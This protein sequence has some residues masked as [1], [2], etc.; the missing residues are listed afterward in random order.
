MFAKRCFTTMI[1][2]LAFAGLQ[3]G[4]QA[5]ET[6]PNVLLIAI[7]DL[8]DWVGCLG[9]HPDTRTPN[10]DRLAERGVLF[11]NSHSQAPICNPSRSSIMLG[12]RP[13]TTGIYLNNPKHWLVPALE[14]RVTMPRHFAAAGYTTLTTGKI[15]HGS[16][17]PP[18]DFDIVGPRPGQRIDLDEQLQSGFPSS[19]AKLWDFGPQRY[20]EA[21]FADHADATWA[22]GQLEQQRDRPFFIAVG[23]YRPH[24]PFYSPERVFRQVPRSEISLPEVREDDWADIPEIARKL[25]QS[26]A[27]P[28]SWFVNSGKWTDAVQSYLSCVRWTDEQ[29][30]RLL[31][32]LEANGHAGNTVVVLY[33]DH[34]FHL[35]EKQRWAKFSLWERSTHVPFIIAAPGMASGERCIRPAELLSIYPTLIEL[36]GLEPRND[37]DGVSLVP[38]LEDPQAAWDRPAIT[39]HLKDNHAIRT[40]RYRYIRYSDGSEELYDHAEDPDEWNNLAGDPDY[41]GIIRDHARWL[42]KINADQAKR[43]KTD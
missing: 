21:K 7:D 11:E 6:K 18:N 8:N 17:L 2:A 32:A 24:V 22:I 29:C 41:A 30:G 1:W 12:L 15:Y 33:S 27:P 4:L 38:L 31:D 34:G 14:G 28:H 16:G 23:F 9:G 26:N 35:G 13:S 10:I 5:A 39:T 37:L 25:T 19:V 43:V 3:P 36:C 40:E 42:P 20:E